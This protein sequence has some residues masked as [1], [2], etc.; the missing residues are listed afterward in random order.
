M[1]KM[2]YNGEYTA[3]KYKAYETTDKFIIQDTG[4]EIPKINIEKLIYKKGEF[5]MWAIKEDKVYFMQA[6][7]MTLQKKAQWHF[8]KWQELMEEAAKI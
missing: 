6:I 5:Y 7:K 4:A 2:T 1:Y 3:E 8:K